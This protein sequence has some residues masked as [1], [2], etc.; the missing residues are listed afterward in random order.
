MKD[1]A[2]G[3]RRLTSWVA[4]AS[5]V[6]GLIMSEIKL[7]SARACPFA[8]RTRLVLGEKKLAFELIEIDL[9]NKPAWYGGVSLYGKVPALEHAGQRIVESAI[10]NEYLEEVFREPRL[11]P[12]DPGQRAL[13]R[14][15]IDFA[16]T[17]LAPAFT[18]VL[19]GATA[20]DREAAKRDLG[21]ALE[22]IEREALAKLSGSG[23]YWFGAT[24]TLVDLTFYP[25]F[26]RL[27]ALERH[28]G[29]DV[30]RALERVHRFWKAVAARESVTAIENSTDFYLERYRAY[31]PILPAASSGRDVNVATR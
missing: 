21:A 24:P 2:D 8:H 19:R 22:L 7:Y 6:G 14:I 30:P 1:T 9:A 16:N 25:W 27:R 31:Q 13:A 18:Q 3:F 10:I 20:H 11:L 15:W 5:P 23:P 4:G 28:T 26:E 12:S 17:R 29:F